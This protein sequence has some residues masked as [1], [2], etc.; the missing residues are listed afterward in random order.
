[1][2]G[3]GWGVGYALWISRRIYNAQMRGL[4]TGAVNNVSR[5]IYSAY[6]VQFNFR[7][8]IAVCVKRIT[9]QMTELQS[10]G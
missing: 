8:L 6:E 3:R 5:I 7:K 2:R 10:C 4:L 9:A 1:M